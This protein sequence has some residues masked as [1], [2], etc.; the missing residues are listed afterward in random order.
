MTATGAAYDRR[1]HPV[2]FIWER[3]RAEFHFCTY[4]EAL[5]RMYQTIRCEKQDGHRHRD[6]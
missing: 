3:L 6:H 4:K 2:F 5:V 1:R